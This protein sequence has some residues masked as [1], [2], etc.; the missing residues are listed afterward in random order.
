MKSGFIE[1]QFKTA[2]PEEVGVDSAAINEFI[3]RMT[4]ERLGLQ[5][6]MIYKN[7]RLA[8]A[9]IASPYRFTDK[10]HD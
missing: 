9:D 6:Y 5:G 10:R 3:K 2:S 1:Y 4:D 8:A 7:G